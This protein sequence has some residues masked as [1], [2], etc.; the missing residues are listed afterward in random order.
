[1]ETRGSPVRR[2]GLRTS[3]AGPCLFLRAIRD[4]ARN[5]ALGQRILSQQSSAGAGGEKLRWDGPGRARLHWSSRHRDD[6]GLGATKRRVSRLMAGAGSR[7]SDVR[8]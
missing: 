8:Q 4:A 1:M 2:T 6:Q 3:V 5:K 7:G